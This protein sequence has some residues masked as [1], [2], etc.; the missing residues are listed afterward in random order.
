MRRLLF[1]VASLVI[2]AWGIRVSAATL[3]VGSSGST[4]NVGGTVTVTIRVNAG[5]Q[6][7]NAAEGTVTYPSQLLKLNSVSKAGT[8]FTFWALEPTTATKGQVAFIGGLPHP[9][10]SGSN[11]TVMKLTFTALATGKATIGFS[12][13]KVLA[14]D[15]YGTNIISG[16]SGTTVTIAEGSGATTTPAP[17]VAI[18]GRPTITVT[19]STHPDQ[20][21]WLQTDQANVEWKKPSGLLGV[22]Y[23]LDQR[24]S[25]DPDEIVDTTDDHASLVL[26]IDGVWYLHIRGKYD[27]GWSATSNYTLRR[28]STPPEHF[29]VTVNQDRGSSD[30]TPELMFSASDSTSSVGRY[31]MSIDGNDAQ[32]VTS[33]HVLEA[34]LPGSHS[35][36]ITAIDAAGNKRQAEAD[37]V[38]TG[39][40]PPT[41]SYVSSPIVL[42]DPLIVRGSAQAG[43]TVI[44]YVNGQ[45]VGQT[46]VGAGIEQPAGDTS[47]IRV[48]WSM[49]V[50]RLFKPG[51]ITVTATATSS[52]GRISVTTD[53]ATV[54]VVGQAI[55]I[56]GR[57]VATFSVVTPIAVCIISLLLTVFAVIARLCVAVWMMH[58]REAEADEAVESLRTANQRQLLTRQQIDMA[59]EKIEDTLE[60]EKVVK[61]RIRKRRPR[62]TRRS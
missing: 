22:S 20:A 10:Y 42:L 12:G 4:V 33:P 11:G 34:L 58:R 9:G 13:G 35:V 41:V 7:I 26:P 61:R 62:T 18:P 14:D 17:A 38:T 5:G 54:R 25:G 2:A 6:S 53:P 57:P 45:S 51:T 29:T 19:S 56:N 3:S 1:I 27:G 32:S 46:V 31:T 16:Q 43:D 55:L 49:T 28:D 44:V 48:P 40:T 8:I 23:I 47:V 30:P 37:V 39:Y 21:V 59:L 15:G 60:G 36:V 50:D 52:D 24:S